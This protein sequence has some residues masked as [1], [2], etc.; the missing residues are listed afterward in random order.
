MY[1]RHLEMFW[2][3]VIIFVAA[4]ECEKDEELLHD[5]ET[6][7]RYVVPRT[8]YLKPIC[9]TMHFNHTISKKGCF[10]VVIQNNYCIGKCNSMYVPTGNED[11]LKVCSNC[12]PSNYEWT[13]IVLS[14]PDRKKKFKVMNMLLIHSCACKGDPTC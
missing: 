11:P 4:V 9:K 8:K 13:R 7:I 14:C 1:L 12:M 10:K 6:D 2:I 3:F 5:W